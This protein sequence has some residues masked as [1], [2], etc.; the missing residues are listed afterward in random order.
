MVEKYRFLLRLGGE[1]LREMFHTEVGFGLLGEFLMV[2]CQ[3]FSPGDEVAVTA[4]LQGLSLTGRFS[5]GV[6]LL[7]EEERRAC[8]SLFYKLLETNPNITEAPE[9]P[10]ERPAECEM[11]PEENTAQ[12]ERKIKGLMAKYRVCEM[13]R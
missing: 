9:S 7:S 13:A 11:Q 2:L 8:Q 6:S 5:L 12:V 4:V 3:C 10:K 1:K